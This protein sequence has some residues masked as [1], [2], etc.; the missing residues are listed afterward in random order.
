M[1]PKR[2][3]WWSILPVLCILVASWSFSVALQAG[4]LR[5][6]LSARLA[7]SFGRPVEVAHFGF[8]L[9]GGPKFEADSVTVS[10]DPR[11]G[12]EYFLRADRLTARLRWA[13]LLHGRMEF[14]ELSLNRPSL[15]LVRLADG[16]WNVETWLP[17]AK[18]LSSVGGYRPPVE[19]APHASQIDIEGGRINFKKGAE[20]LTFALVNV[21]GSVNLQSAGRWSLDL[22][23][24]P[25]RAAVVL[26]KSG[27]LRL[28]GTIGGTSARLQPADLRL[29]W[30]DASLA[31]AAR[32]VRGTDYGLRGM[33]DADFGARISRAE[34][35]EI[36]SPWQIEGGLRLQAIHGWDLVGR[37][38]NPAVNVK[39]T[40]VLY[41]AESRLDVER[42]LVEAPH[43]NLGGAASIDW[44]HG[45][46]PELHLLDSQIGFPDLVNWSHAFFPGRGE[47]LEISGSSGL[48]G[49]FSGWPLRVD[50]FGAISDGASIQSDNG[51]LA[52]IRIGPVEALWSHS[53]LVVAP[54][55]V[56]VSSPAS[57]RTSRGL[58]SQAVSAGLFHIDAVLGPIHAGVALRDW[59]YRMAISGQTQRLQDLRAVIAAVGWQFGT[60]WNIE[61]PASL[62][63][64]CSGALRRGSS[65]IHGQLDLRNVRLTSSSV[66]EPI[67]VSAASVGFSPGERRVKIGGVEALGALWNGA[68]QQTIPN[69]AWTFD[70]S[71]SRLDLNE[72]GQALAQNRQGLFYRLLP[73][74]E[75]SGLTPQTA[76]A[77]ARI[78][79]QGHLHIDE[80]ALGSSRLESLDATADLEQGNLTLR[81][82]EADLY[83]G[84][85]TGEFRAQLGTDLSYSFRGQVDRTDLSALASLSSIK[86]GFSGI[87]SG[88][89][90][91]S[92]RGLGRQALLASL[93]GEGFLQVQ[94]A[95]INLLN[96]PVIPAD[97]SFQD[98]AGN[99]FRSSTVSFRIENG[100]VRVDPWLL[101]GRQR[102]LEIVGD[103]DFSRRIDLQVRSL[104]QSDR[105]SQASD[106]PADDDIWVLGGTLDA[107]QIIRE[108]RVSAG[109]ESIVHSGR[110]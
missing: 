17:P 76:A 56:H 65:F 86:E 81:R 16:Q 42:W 47:N 40:A 74:A 102:Q 77:I 43:S 68:F 58:Q 11:F 6:S 92:A 78:N 35:D 27:T 10:E 41:P 25:M 79:A 106:P 8:T 108:E 1:L 101:S 37:P 23:A 82:A 45:I 30:E 60:N 91:L 48:E 51:G 44:S 95:A 22:A 64:M 70:L 107:P 7:A 75:P 13:A 104:S 87:G 59:P 100:Q 20:K 26:Q 66:T 2:H 3:F 4:W 32:L 84:R 21:S 93:E 109:N 103:I 46:N 14:A 67:L 94:D 38:D 50:H 73:F 19:Q 90:A 39:V 53:S 105:V 97:T 28:R 55:T 61:G 24:Q 88:E 80:L 63:L 12:E 33:L 71:A 15:N 98:I 54:V 83:G 52:R 31:D 5:R 89:I 110:R 57:R 36:G 49:T 72:L 62:Q 9:W 96:L 99:R 18:T 85:L 69:A 29:S 34:A